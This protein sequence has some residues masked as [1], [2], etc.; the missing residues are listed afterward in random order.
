MPRSP[1][2]ARARLS[3]PALVA[4]L[5]SLAL[6]GIGGGCAATTSGQGGAPLAPGPAAGDR[7]STSDPSGAT[8][9]DPSAWLDE[10]E[11]ALASGEL[12]RAATLFARYLGHDGSGERGRQAYAGLARAHE[13]L[14]DF[15]AAIRA[16]DG[17]LAR[18][19]DDP[20]AHLMLARRGACEAQVLA[21]ERSAA[22]YAQ[23]IELGGDALI[24]SQQVEALARQGFALY[25]LGQLEQADAVLANADAIYE[26]ATSA[27]QER[28]SDTYFVA[29]AR[30]YRAA[31]LHLEFRKVRIRLP[32]AQMDADFE[33]KLALLER[34]QAAYNEVVRARHVYW[35]SAAGYQLGSLFE[36]FYDAIMYAPV[37]DWLDDAQRRTYYLELEEQLRPVIDK[38]VWVF[39]KNLETARKL[40]YDNEFIELTQAQLGHLQGIVLGRGEGGGPMP[41]LAPRD[42]DDA[43][44]SDPSM[45]SPQDE[46]PAVERKLF[47]PMPTTL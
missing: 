26:A 16:Y 21:W 14:G 1:T 24:P 27:G 31:I 4:A 47:V 45:P 11:R 40:G 23:V 28:F 29:M 10:A 20:T 33:A 25:Q 19:G 9:T 32:E 2:L 34:A 13:L 43:D 22:S 35:V 18:F 41:R 44:S 37:P 30:F 8:S 6:L 46:L 15:D 42:P 17:F 7:A 12:A 39:E 36:E 3:S 38:A 5:A